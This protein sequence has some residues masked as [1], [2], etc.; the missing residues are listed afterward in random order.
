MSLDI[1]AIARAL[2][3]IIVLAP[4]IALVVLALLSVVEAPA[5]ERWTIRVT[6]GAVVSGLLAGLIM[7]VIAALGGHRGIEVHLGD[8]IALPVE[9]YHF[10][11]KFLFD[12]LSLTFLMLS[13]ILTS[14][15][16]AFARVYLHRDP[17]HRRFYLLFMVF[18][19]GMTVSSI[20]GTIETLFAG[21]ELVGLSSALLVGFFQERPAPVRNAL[22]VWTVYRVADAAFLGAT[23][24]LHHTAAEGDF[25]LLAGGRIWPDGTLSLGTGTTLVVGVLLLVAAAGKS[26]LLPFSGW[27]P[28]A[29]EGPTPSSA[30][31][32]GALSVHLGAFLLLRTEA[33]IET[34]AV[35][36]ALVVATGL[37][38]ALWATLAGKARSDIKSVLSYASLAQV[39][40][41]VAE[42][43]L[44]LR[45]VALV[46][47]VGNACLRTLQFLRAPSVL[48]D[49]HRIES[50]VGGRRRDAALL[51]IPRLPSKLAWGLYRSSYE[52]TLFDV[53]LDRWIVE[54]FTA[55]LGACERLERAWMRALAGPAAMR[56]GDRPPP[57]PTVDPWE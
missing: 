12:P 43:G 42:I 39:G 44:G 17:G 9:H 14:V 21:W 8:W 10:A 34:S 51:S 27:L 41:I 35:L 4:L 46:H 48:H 52:H 23:V 24:A 50:A 33:L 16:G 6:M 53:L 22:R 54:P 15:V 19:L 26:G 11:F 5:G 56:P 47:L 49:H 45:Y 20:A 7:V 30:I 38:T 29:M 31:F 25:A 18:V 28:R 32:Y 55:V 36:G 37:G 1:D 40:L 3:T 57:T 2:C 13:L